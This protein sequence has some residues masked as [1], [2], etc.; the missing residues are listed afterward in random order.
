VAGKEVIV[1][2]RV[3]ATWGAIAVLSASLTA[4]TVVLLR[5][6]GRTVAADD[7]VAGGPLAPVGIAASV[8]A[9]PGATGPSGTS[10]VPQLHVDPESPAAAWATGNGSD[11]RSAVIR[12]EIAVHAAALWLRDEGPDEVGAAVRAAVDRA[13]PQGASP[14]VVLSA[15]D[16][17][18][19]EPTVVGTDAAARIADRYAAVAAALGGASAVV[20]VEPMALRVLTCVR[21][22]AERTGR[23][24]IVADA[25]TRLRADAPA[26]VVYLGG[27]GPGHADAQPDVMADRLIAAGA[28]DA[29]GFVLNVLDVRPNTE[30]GEFAAEVNR[31]LAARLGTS[32]PYAVDTSRNGANPPPDEPCNSPALRTGEVPGRAEGDAGS[33]AD[34]PE[35]RLWLLQPGVSQGACGIGPDSAWGEFL[36]DLAVAMSGATP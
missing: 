18:S 2:W 29:R 3:V 26:A 11:P 17:M 19:C 8:A 34:A 9:P 4:A 27:G 24:A 16:L 31:Q 20:V 1:L 32:L 10:P 25:V 30:S 7:L 5:S 6:P 28:G 12:S 21:D 15:P 33:V 35:L 22:D 13:A 23:L 36:P 14:V